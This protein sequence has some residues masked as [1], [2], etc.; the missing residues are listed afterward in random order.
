[1]QALFNFLVL[2]DALGVS[3]TIWNVE[4]EEEET[5]TSSPKRIM[6]FYNKL[7]TRANNLEIYGK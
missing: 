5:S 4:E 3:D 1:M 6:Q 2:G 7:T